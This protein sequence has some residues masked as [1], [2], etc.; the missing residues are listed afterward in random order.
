[1]KHSRI[2]TIILMVVALALALAPST[3]LAATP[4]QGNTVTIAANQTVN[5]DVYAA[6]NTVII[7]GRVNGDVVAFA[8][9][10]TLNGVVTG[11]LIAA[12]GT[13]TIKGR[14]DGTV[15][16]AGG[17]ITVDGVVGR[18][19]LVGA[20][21][22]TLGSG[23][24][25]G[26]DL[27][28]GSGTTS[29]SGR[30]A[31]DVR[32]GSGTLQLNSGAVV[33]GNISYNGNVAP[34]IANGATV[35][36]TVQESNPTGGWTWTGWSAPWSVGNPGNTLVGW[37]Q[38]LIGMLILGLAIVWLAPRFSRRTINRMERSPWQS[39]GL[40]LVLLITVPI[41][42]GL[43]FVLG[44]LVGG[45]WLALILLALL[46][47]ALPVSMVIAGLSIGHWVMER[48]GRI[49]VGL[50][51]ELLVGLV[52]LGLVSLVPVFGAVAL[53]LASLFGFGALVMSATGLTRS[54]ERG[55]RPLEGGV[56]A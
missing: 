8:G 39:G 43:V 12:G 21:T 48:V 27:L 18:D 14:V 45:W 38:M 13:T 32:V 3:V 30:I 50:G 36:G 17:T 51:W 41:V 11:N 2:V 7:D 40:G 42:A 35:H 46:V 19:L 9:T 26:R 15:R 34:T 33:G 10:V 44:L 24:R 29:V 56:L 5:D 25:I 37:L 28:T 22:V 31:R 53:F 16:V 4:L 20:G 54:L 55:E 49:N 47:L 6:G 52:L 23:A 1:M